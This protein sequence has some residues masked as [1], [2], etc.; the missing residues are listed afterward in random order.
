MTSFQPFLDK[1][2]CKC[3]WYTPYTRNIV[4]IAPGKGVIPSPSKTNFA[5]CLA[6]SVLV[7]CLTICQCVT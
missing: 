1:T 2:Q 5:L 6:P 4:V 3:T 7:S